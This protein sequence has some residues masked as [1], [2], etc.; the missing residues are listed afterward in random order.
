MAVAFDAA[1]F[2]Y[3]AATVTLT[4]N[5]TCTGS[6]RALVVW[7]FG[8]H[9]GQDP[10]SATYNS[11]SMAQHAAFDSNASKLYV[12][13]APATGSNQVAIT[14]AASDEVYGIAFSV[15]GADQTTPFDTAVTQFG[16]GPTV[17]SATDDLVVAFM[18]DE[19]GGS[20]VTP[21]QIEV[22][23]D[24]QGLLMAFCQYAAGASPNVAMTYSVSGAN[25]PRNMA[26]N[27]NAAAVA[28]GIEIFR[29]RMEH[30]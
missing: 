5:H 27:I 8:G 6:E 18:G 9:S 28:A 23:D 3:N 21:D 10:S 26:V 20:S 13:T 22:V 17:S 29:R 19:S 11:V 30:D 16:G 25:S 12:L 4:F 1:S 2:G 15:T 24:A 14:F 7:A